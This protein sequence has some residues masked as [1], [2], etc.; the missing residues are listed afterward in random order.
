M[1]NAECGI[2]SVGRRAITD[3]PYIYWKPKAGQPSQSAQALTALPE[4]EPRYCPRVAVRT[5]SHR[6]PCSETAK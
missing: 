2:E 1:R 5:Y 3:R 4:G 6:A